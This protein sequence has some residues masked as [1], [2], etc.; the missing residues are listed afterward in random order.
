MTAIPPHEFPPGP[1]PKRTR[2]GLVIGLIAGGLVVLCC[3]GGAVFFGLIALQSEPAGAAAESYVDAVIAGDNTEALRYVCSADD[4][5][6]HHAVFTD[7]VHS[8]GVSGGQVVNTRV[9]LWNLSWQATVRMELTD[10]TGARE[11]A[12]LPLAKEDGKWKVC[13]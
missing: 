7:F 12:E 13:N 3:A 5:L 2:W 6:A 9:T 10:S 1:P 8:N 4:S 11:N